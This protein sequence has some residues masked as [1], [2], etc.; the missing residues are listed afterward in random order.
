MQFEKESCYPENEGL[1]FIIPGE[2]TFQREEEVQ[3]RIRNQWQQLYPSACWHGDAA[4]RQVP[5]PRACTP[6]KD[7]SQ[8]QG[9]GGLPLGNTALSF[10]ELFSIPHSCH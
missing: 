5:S 9:A 3:K 10:P 1:S 4:V 8:N 7:A 6:F 2:V